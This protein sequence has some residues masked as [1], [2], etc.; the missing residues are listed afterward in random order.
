MQI[1]SKYK[2]DGLHQI[3]KTRKPFVNQGETAI[4]MKK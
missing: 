2:T 1:K 4:S 3:F